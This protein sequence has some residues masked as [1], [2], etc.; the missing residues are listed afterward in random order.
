MSE[1]ST[2]VAA[3]LVRC[4]KLT[5]IWQLSRIF[6]GIASPVAFC[7]ARIT[8]TPTLRPFRT[9]SSTS[10]AVCRATA[11]RFFDSTSVPL[12][13]LK[14]VCA[15]SITTTTRGHEADGPRCHTFFTPSTARIHR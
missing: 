5:A 10:R 3:S 7:V 1:P 6:V 13:S 12:D 9:N 11:S 8:W 2:A 14:N 4:A 15:S